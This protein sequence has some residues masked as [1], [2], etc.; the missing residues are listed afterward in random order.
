MTIWQ[1]EALPEVERLFRVIR[2]FVDRDGK[3]WNVGPAAGVW[4]KC[5][6]VG[7]AASVRLGR[8]TASK[9]ARK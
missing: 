2:A 5:P 3:I 4:S 9:I 6:L 1:L 7:G 8:D